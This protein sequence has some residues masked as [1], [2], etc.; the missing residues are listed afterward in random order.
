MLQMRRPL[1][2]QRGNSRPLPIAITPIAPPSRYMLGHWDT[3]MS[4]VRVPKLGES[5]TEATIARWFKKAGDA[6]AVDDPLVEIET[7]K[8]TIEVP[9]PSAGVLGEILAK[10]GETVAVGELLGQIKV[11]S[12]APSDLVVGK[13]RYPLRSKSL[14]KYD[15]AVMRLGY[16]E[17]F[18]PTWDAALETISRRLHRDFQTLW[19]VAPHER[20]ASQ[21]AQL[22]ELTEIIDLEEYFR[23]NRQE[24]FVIGRIDLIDDYVVQLTLLTHE[25]RQITAHIGEL[26]ALV[27]GMQS[28]Q[29][30]EARILTGGD[31]HIEW[32]SWSVRPP[33]REDDDAWTDFDRL[34]SRA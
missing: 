8:V 32:K 14:L 17:A 23:A 16:L 25:D 4:E 11:V 27:A 34:T 26:P 5:V 10:D 21:Q 24:E 9:A 15:G 28:G 1:R 33:L 18:S 12:Q 30:F 3:N 2:P 6:V 22:K 7:D 13:H 29:Y 31:H 20:S 19:L